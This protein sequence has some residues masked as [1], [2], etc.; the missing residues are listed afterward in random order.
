M[1]HEYQEI[2]ELLRSARMEMRISLPEAAAKL[3]IRPRYLEA[4]EEGNFSQLPGLSYTKGYLARY[5]V[6]LRLDKA[7]VMRRFERIE[8]ALGKKGFYLP[9]TFS[10][11]QAP[12]SALVW[13]GALGALLLVVLGNWLL[14]PGRTEAPL[15][16]SPQAHGPAVLLSARSAAAIACLKPAQSLMPPCHWPAAPKDPLAKITQR[17]Y[18]AALE[19]ISREQLPLQLEVPSEPTPKTIAPAARDVPDVTEE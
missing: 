17:E 16:D 14:S 13:G 1:S 2:G 3:H 4:L 10:R 15:V 8:D 12:H 9:L 5:S 18:T 7:E 11:E 19:A 6:F